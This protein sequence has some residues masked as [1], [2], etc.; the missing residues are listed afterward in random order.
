MK[1]TWEQLTDNEQKEAVDRL[2]SMA[3]LWR[4]ANR[5]SSPRDQMLIEAAVNF[6][7]NGR[8]K[9]KKLTLCGV[10]YPGE[11]LVV[12]KEIAGHSGCHSDRRGFLSTQW[13]VKEG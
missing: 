1:K 11:P 13:I 8:R 4:T 5:P 7:D 6:V 9:F 10:P 2:H 3:Y 12:C